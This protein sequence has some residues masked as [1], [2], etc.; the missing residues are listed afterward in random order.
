MTA[1]YS[2][3]TQGLFSVIEKFEKFY[4]I[5]LIEFNSLEN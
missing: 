3:Q 2:G 5:N 1:I 4:N